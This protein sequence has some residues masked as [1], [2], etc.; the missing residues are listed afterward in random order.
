MTLASEYGANRI[1]IVNV[2]DLKPL[3]LPIEF[4]IRLAWN[5]KAIGREQIGEY[6]QRWACREFGD[7]YANEI[8]EIVSAYTKYNGWRK[9]EVV[10]PDT[11]SLANYQEAERVWEAWESITLRAEA[12]YKRL[13]EEL[14]PAFF[15]LVLHPAKASGIV[16]QMNIA[17]G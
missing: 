14:Q 15:Q 4:F 5:P 16:T 8:S 1:W 17:A 3:E 10:T 7:T 11:Y 6:T 2:G 13:P 9:P 12:L